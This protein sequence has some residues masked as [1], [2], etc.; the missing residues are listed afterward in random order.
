MT[1]LSLEYGLLIVCT[2]IV[3]WLVN[4]RTQNLILLAGS[5]GFYS[6]I[7][8]RL[9]LILAGY[10]IVT[11]V[12]VNQIDS[13]RKNSTRYLLIAITATL[14]TLILFKFSGFFVE[15]I[16]ELLGQAGLKNFESNLRIIM[17]IG[18]SFYT[19][20]S[21]GY[22]IDVYMRRMSARTS[23]VDTA[24]F[25]SFF[26]QLIAG[27]IERASN[28]IPQFEAPRSFNT[29]KIY[30]GSALIS[31]GLLKKLVIADNLGVIVDSIFSTGQ[32]GS[33]MLWVGIFA[34]GIQ[35]LADF[36]GYT[37]IAR[38]TARILGIDLSINFRHPWLAKSPSDFWKRWHITL[39]EWLRDY[40]YLPLGGNQK[41][42]RRTSINLAIVFILGGIWHGAGWNFVLWGIFH[43]ILLIVWRGFEV[44]R[45]SAP[46]PIPTI[47][48]FIVIG[49]SWML[50]RE[51]DITY[52]V[53]NA[54]GQSQDSKLAQALAITA[55]IYALPLWIHAAID[56]PSI[57]SIWQGHEV[58]KAISLTAITVTSFLAI[59]ALRAPVSEEFIYF[60][61]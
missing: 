23:F 8:P 38:G 52:L 33:A 9:A 19:F 35:I 3:Y 39:S 31:W 2:L 17:P 12:T 7:D 15:N 11:Y 55:L 51:R 40:V 44:I 1:F 13:D 42:I 29:N 6:Y 36:S 54:V 47:I 10:T 43:A 50:F 25:V 57:K 49:A 46:K 30:S 24:L 53:E 60:Q 34:F 32:P 18:I 5:Y 26:P 59:L 4:C 58:V 48:T 22:C 37:D 27:P 45:I 20:Q 21:L 16:A 61:F 56:R 28:L 14:G 41:G